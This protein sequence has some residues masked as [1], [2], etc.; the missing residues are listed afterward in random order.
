MGG[1]GS[2]LIGS[3]AHANALAV[4]PDAVAEVPAGGTLEVM[5]LDPP[6]SA[7]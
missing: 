5:V 2:H 4:V 6:S 7:A 1:H 3:L